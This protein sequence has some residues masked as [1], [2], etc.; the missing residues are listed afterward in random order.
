M[1]ISHPLTASALAPAERELAHATGLSRLPAIPWRDPHTVSPQKLAEVI[2]AFKEACALSPE[3]ADIRV[4]LGIAYAMNYDVYL[5]MDVLEEARTLEPQNFL[6]QF[7]YA[8]LQYRLRALEVAE[9]ETHK[10]L[11]LASTPWELGQARYQLSEI[12][13]LRREGTIKPSWTKSLL[14]PMICFGLIMAVV[15]VLY[16][17]IP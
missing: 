13:R 3:N 12:R 14:I 7:K 9:A 2:A 1:S 15:A 10:A 8:E 17:V 4:C 16:R 11:V 6:A 5:S